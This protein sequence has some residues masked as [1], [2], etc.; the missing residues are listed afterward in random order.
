MHRKATTAIDIVVVTVPRIAKETVLT[1]LIIG[2]IGV[3]F[4]HF[5]QG[6]A[7]LKIIFG[8][9]LWITALFLFFLPF[10]ISDYLWYRRHPGREEEF[11]RIDRELDRSGQ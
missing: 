6:T 9:A 7:F 4:D 8:L 5:G 1:V 10:L 11:A 3:I 2:I